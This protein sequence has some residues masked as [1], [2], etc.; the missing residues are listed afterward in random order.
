MFR[1]LHHITKDYIFCDCKDDD[2][3]GA[4]F[5]K[6]IQYGVV[7]CLNFSGKDSLEQCFV[8]NMTFVLISLI[9]QVV[10]LLYWLT[11]KASSITGVEI[12]GIKI[13]LM[14]LSIIF[15][16]VYVIAYISYS[17]S[18]IRRL[19]DLG[20]KVELAIP[21]IVFGWMLCGLV[22]F[23]YNLSIMVLDK[24]DLK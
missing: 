2:E 1:W 24:D 20:L 12:D 10:L 6:G 4:D 14:V 13:L 18:L 7:N 17:S 22:V 23:Y 3:L 16:F 11:Y 5:S 19:N 15:G 9:F 8:I 21:A